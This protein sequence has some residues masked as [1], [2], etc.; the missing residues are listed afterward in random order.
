MRKFTLSLMMLAMGSL[1]Y[2]NNSY[3]QAP[4]SFNQTGAATPA[5]AGSPTPTGTNYNTYYNASAQPNNST[6]QLIT[7]LGNNSATVLQALQ[8]INKQLTAMDQDVQTGNQTLTNSWNNYVQMQAS[9]NYPQGTG[10]FLQNTMAFGTFSQL[11]ASMPSTS[12][13]SN[14]PGNNS[15]SNNNSNNANAAPVANSLLDSVQY[16]P[17]SNGKTG[18]SSYI[19]ALQNI[20]YNSSAGNQ[21]QNQQVVMSS[22]SDVLNQIAAS[23]TS[24]A[25][26]QSPMAMVGSVVS[27][28]M[29]PAWADSIATASNTQLL[30]AAVVQLSVNNYLMYQRYQQEQATQ[31]LLA[32]QVVLLQQIAQSLQGAKH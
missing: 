30:R 1:A 27:A 18:A 10:E 9:A 3:F 21:A 23:R 2:A 6:S 12:G 11:A 8:Q 13:S 32:N 26:S 19:D 14:N 24:G 15:N 29:Q 4:P 20:I 17:S 22:V 5:A 7:A 25:N 31:T 28:S 16:A